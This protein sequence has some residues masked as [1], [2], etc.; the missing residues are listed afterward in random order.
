MRK[1]QKIRILKDNSIGII[2]DS[3]FFV[4]DG[5]KHIRYEVRKKN[6]REGRWFPAEELGPVTSTLKVTMSCDNGQTLYADLSMNYDK[7]NLSLALTGNPDNLKVHKGLH[8]TIMNKL[9]NS[10]NQ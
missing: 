10:L 1:G 8:V 4:L 7:E 6:E 2:A 9:L 5:K 3:T